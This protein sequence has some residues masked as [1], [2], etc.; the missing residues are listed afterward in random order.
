ML[1]GSGGIPPEVG[2]EWPEALGLQL[3]NV[4]VNQMGGSVTLNYNGGTEVT[5]IF[6][7]N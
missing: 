7:M 4:L 3:V 1:W 5:I 2:L 6:E